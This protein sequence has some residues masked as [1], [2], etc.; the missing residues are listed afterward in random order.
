MTSKEV[1]IGIDGADIDHVL[2]QPKV[3]PVLSL[4]IV[5]EHG[6]NLVLHPCRPKAR[7]D[8]LIRFLLSMDSGCDQIKVYEPHFWGHLEHMRRNKY[9]ALI[10]HHQDEIDCFHRI[11]VRNLEVA[12]GS[13]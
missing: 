3:L 6:K 1:H 4:N 12:L 13:W 2:C 8:I 7:E 9:Q 11:V 10:P 5:V